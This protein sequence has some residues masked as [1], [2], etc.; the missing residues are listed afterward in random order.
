VS[1]KAA[2]SDHTAAM[3]V[4]RAA[5]VLAERGDAASMADIA[6]VAGVGRATLY[7]YFPNRDL[8]LRALADAALD[9]LDARLTEAQLDAV[10]VPEAIA[11]LARAFLATGGSYVALMRTGHQPSDPA[12]VDRRIEE[13]LRAL[14]RRGIAAGALR[15]DLPVETLLAMFSGLVEA[16][17]ALSARAGGVEQASTAITAV[18]LHGVTAA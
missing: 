6:D 2:L 17:I 4:R 10:E 12:A 5:L 13:P 1:K 7:R 9:E 14:F 18:F 3:I 16:G 8:L 11:R 15:S